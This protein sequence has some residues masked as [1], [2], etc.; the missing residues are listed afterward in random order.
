MC[1]VCA[2]IDVHLC[3]TAPVRYKVLMS[4]RCGACCAAITVFISAGTYSI[5]R[6]RFLHTSFF[7]LPFRNFVVPYVE[8]SLRAGDNFDSCLFDAAAWDDNNVIFYFRGTW[9]HHVTRR[10]CSVDLCP[11][12]ALTIAK[13][14]VV[15]V[16][17]GAA[18]HCPLF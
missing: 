3:C 5:S 14:V 12:N 1:C 4:V 17:D 18:M 9:L 16:F 13:R 8:Y 2:V 11:P 6:F 7:L 15:I 10:P